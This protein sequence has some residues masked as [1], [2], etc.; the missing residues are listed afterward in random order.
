LKS[1]PICLH[2]LCCLREGH[3][4]DEQKLRRKQWETSSSEEYF[5]RRKF[6]IPSLAIME[7]PLGPGHRSV[8][9]KAYRGIAPI[10]RTRQETLATVLHFLQ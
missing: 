7:K 10:R 3:S 8:A 6:Y 1:I 9:T 2:N 5:W 4:A